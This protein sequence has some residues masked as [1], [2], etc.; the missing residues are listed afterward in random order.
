MINKI[1]RLIL[2]LHLSPSEAAQRLA[3]IVHHA[4]MIWSAFD[5]E[6]FLSEADAVLAY[7]QQRQ[8]EEEAGG[9]DSDCGATAGRPG[10]QEQEEE[11]AFRPSAG[12]VAFGSA[13]DGWAFTVPDF[14]AQYAEKLGAKPAALA[15]AMWGDY[16]FLPKEKRVV[17]L[18]RQGGSGGGGQKTM[19]EQFALEPL[20]K[21]YGACGAAGGAEAAALLAPIVKGRGLA[22]RV[23][24]KALEAPDPRQ[25]LRAVL[26]AWLPLSEAVLSMAV[27]HLPSP[28]EAAPAR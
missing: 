26:R 18:K 25:A 17:K 23:P 8:A 4:N 20:W 15:Q 14:A 6:A 12:N 2:E 7:E 16:A 11:D 22:A 3:A 9:G 28:P 13:A 19:F 1:D 27:A 24:A 5:S 10:E 21:A